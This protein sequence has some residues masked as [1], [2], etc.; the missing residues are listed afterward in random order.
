VPGNDLSSGRTPSDLVRQLRL[1]IAE[2]A[3]LWELTEQVTDYYNSDVRIAHGPWRA[4]DCQQI[5]SRWFDCGLIDCIAVSWAT[6]VRSDEVVHYDYGA[7]WRTRA[8]ET[9]QHLIL[10]RED[11]GGLLI[12]PSTWHQEGIG[13]GVMLCQSDEADGLSFDD[14]IAKLA[15][16]PDLLIYKNPPNEASG[17]PQL[18]EIE[19]E[20]VL[21]ARAWT[22]AI[23]NTATDGLPIVCPVNRDAD[24]DIGW[25]PSPDDYPTAEAIGDIVWFV[26]GATTVF[27][28]GRHRLRCPGC[29]AEQFLVVT[30]RPG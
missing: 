6:R 25:T 8:T 13:A 3:F 9:G 16:L 2:E 28:F 21:T 14:W 5:L 19:P 12:D 15:G 22:R 10:A 26:D 23:Q 30:R 17:V 11:A 18:T 7:G 20:V 1:L 4:T 27:P 24:L 29:G